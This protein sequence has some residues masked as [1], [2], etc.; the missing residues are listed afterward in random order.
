MCVYVL[1]VCKCV[2]MC[3]C[4]NKLDSANR[5]LF[6]LYFFFCFSFS[7]PHFHSFILPLF[8]LF[9]IVVMYLKQI[10]CCLWRLGHASLSFIIFLLFST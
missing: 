3:V 2:C 4:V 5:C 10:C 1:A 8:V 6:L 9:F 7:F